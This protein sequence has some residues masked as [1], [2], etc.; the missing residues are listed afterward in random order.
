MP[1]GAGL[2]LGLDSPRHDTLGADLRML[3]SSGRLVIVGA[4]AAAVAM[5]RGSDRF[6]SRVRT[7]V[8]ALDPWALPAEGKGILGVHLTRTAEARPALVALA[9]REVFGMIRSGLVRPHV[10]STFDVADI[11]RAHDRLHGR[12]SIGKVVVLFEGA[13]GTSG[14]T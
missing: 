7:R 8:E 12:E 2:D 13:T 6:A 11:L 1:G 14:G 3:A 10:D 9:L 4:T 5:A